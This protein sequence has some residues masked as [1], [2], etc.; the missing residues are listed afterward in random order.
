MRLLQPIAA[1]ISVALVIALVL[2]YEELFSAAPKSVFFSSPPAAADAFSLSA[3]ATRA[4]LYASAKSQHKA[5]KVYQG[6]FRY[7]SDLAPAPFWMVLPYKSSHVYAGNVNEALWEKGEMFGEQ[8]ELEVYRRVLLKHCSGY[9]PHRPRVL[10]VGSN[11][12]LFSALAIAHGCAA[13]TVDGAKD[14]LLYFSATAAMNGWDSTVSTIVNNVVSDAEAGSFTF[15]GWNTNA[16]TTSGA[17]NPDEYASQVPVRLDSLADAGDSIIFLKVDV[18]GHEP[19]AFR[20]GLR[21]FSDPA[22][23]KPLTILFEY[24]YI[25]DGISLVDDYRKDVWCV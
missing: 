3:F 12:G 23:P 22:K 11:T 8:A 24:T 10:D 17:T 14:A 2:F 6:G 9:R 25:L 1:V 5:V 16:G 21:L 20:S 4:L 18:E 7:F 13:T 15:N 19:Q